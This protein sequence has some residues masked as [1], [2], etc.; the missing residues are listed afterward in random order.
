MG[1]DGALVRLRDVSF[2]YNSRRPVLDGLDFDMRASDRIGLT[3]ANGSGKTTLLHLLVGL[4]L[5]D[6]GEVEMFG[7][8]RRT[9]KDF[10]E[11]RSRA[12]LLFQ[13][14]EDQLFCPTVAE[15]VAFGPLNLGRSREEVVAIVR[16]TLAETG[17]QGFEERVT[18][19]LSFGEKRLVSLATVLAMRPEVLLLDEPTPGLSPEV[20]ERIV[21]V[22]NRMDLPML[23][24][25]QDYDFLDRVTSSR[26]IL[27]GGRVRPKSNC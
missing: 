7:R 3:G 8:L 20:V 6:R 26:L 9:E 2:S 25:S 13:D 4:L 10:I 16:E 11:V 18:Y 19:R 22:L 24:V 17:L 15:D 5:P 12:G 1:A 21:R 14:P 27:Q 23:V